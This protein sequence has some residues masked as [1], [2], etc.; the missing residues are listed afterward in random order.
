MRD[1]EDEELLPAQALPTAAACKTAASMVEL[2]L[3]RG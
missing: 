1:D 3:G 2:G